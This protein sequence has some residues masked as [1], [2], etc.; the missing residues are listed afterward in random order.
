MA[1]SS[2]P[3]RVSIGFHGGPVLAVRLTEGSFKDLSKALSG[4]G[5]HELETDDGA[6]RIRLEQ[7]VYV[8][9]DSDDPRVGFGS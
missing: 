9:V 8:Q 6:V 4:R 3:Q 1:S 2:K 5:W 7:V